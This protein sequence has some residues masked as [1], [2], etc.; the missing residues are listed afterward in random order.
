MKNK[1]SIITFLSLHM[2]VT[3][4]TAAANPVLHYKPEVVTLK[5][6]VKVRTF[7]RN[8]TSKNYDDGYEIET[9]AY[10][11]LDQPINVATSPKDKIANN[12]PEKDITIV[13]VAILDKSIFPEIKTNNHV[14]VTGYLFHRLKGH[15]HYTKVLIG[16]KNIKGCGVKS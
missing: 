9:F 4:L 13:H 3:S 2:F 8:P 12:K 11:K 15:R 7:L 14:C 1:L 10:L 5:G 16:A 6:V